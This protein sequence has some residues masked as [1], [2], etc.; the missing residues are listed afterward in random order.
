MIGGD[1]AAGA[2]HVLRH[3]RRLAG[4]VPADV[5][6]DRAAPQVVAA[7]RPETD[8]HLHGLAGERVRLSAGGREAEADER[9]CQRDRRERSSDHDAAP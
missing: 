4:E 5:P 6:A 8:D 2:R 9:G 1:E 3:D 7:A